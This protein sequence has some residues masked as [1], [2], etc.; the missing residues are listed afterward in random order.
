[1][2]GNGFGSYNNL[3]DI[4]CFLDANL[5]VVSSV[6]NLVSQLGKVSKVNDPDESQ[7]RV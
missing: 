5:D 7:G 3:K 2:L 6:E 4:G 1:M